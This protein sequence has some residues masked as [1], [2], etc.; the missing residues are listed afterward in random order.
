MPELRE[1][2]LDQLF[3][4]AV[5]LHPSEDE[6][7]LFHDGAADEIT[8][9]RITTHLRQCAG[10]LES[11]ETMRHILATFHEVEVPRESL[12]QLK[13]LIAETSPL[14]A[15]LLRLR[16]AIIGAVLVSQLRRHKLRAADKPEIESDQTENGEL[17]WESG[18]TESGDLIVYL[19]SRHLQLEGAKVIF[20]I[21]LL[22]GKEI[23]LT[24]KSKN[25]VGA[26]LRI[27]AE[28]RDQLPNN[29]RLVVDDL[30]LPATG[31]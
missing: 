23:T 9:A 21:D 17:Q 15:E 14:Q 1:E 27:P 26:E 22:P 30:I 11:F 13:T 18:D 19:R 24:R 28:Q 10:C 3:Q 6:L 2:E 29:A 16:D 5:R 20:R 7:G 25:E 31:N 12:E 8:S 4:Q